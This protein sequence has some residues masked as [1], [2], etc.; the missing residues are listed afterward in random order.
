M[1]VREADGLLVATEEFVGADTSVLDPVELAVEL[2]VVGAADGDAVVTVVVAP[3]I[4]DV[5]VVVVPAGVEVEAAVS[6]A[7]E[8]ATAD[9]LVAVSA[10]AAVAAIAETRIAATT[11]AVRGLL[12]MF[13]PICAE[14]YHPQDA[15]RLDW[16]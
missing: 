15:S 6:I 11:T 9:V 4:V 3:T 5:A 1:H 16:G 8:V 2:L 10:I 13:G 12:R 14:V 7:V